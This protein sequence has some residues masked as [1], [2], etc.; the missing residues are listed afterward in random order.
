MGPLPYLE[1]FWVGP[2][3]EKRNTLYVFGIRFACNKYRHGSI[4]LQ[5][6]PTRA[7]MSVEYQLF[8]LSGRGRPPKHFIHGFSHCGLL[9]SSCHICQPGDGSHKPEGEMVKLIGLL[10]YLLPH[11]HTSFK[12]VHL[13][14]ESFLKYLWVKLLQI[15]NFKYFCGKEIS[16]GGSAG[17]WISSSSRHGEQVIFIN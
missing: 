3:E 6:E 8:F 9:D 17:S 13:A 4:R 16:L 7:N 14:S 11:F 2:F 5:A 15:S 1:L 10:P 12:I